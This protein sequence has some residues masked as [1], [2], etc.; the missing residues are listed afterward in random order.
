MSESGESSIE[1]Q[2]ADRRYE[3]IEQLT[4]KSVKRK[5]TSISWSD[6]LDHVFLNK[7]LGI[8]LFL[9]IMFAMFQFTFEVA[10]PLM[11]LVDW[12]FSLL[13]NWVLLVSENLYSASPPIHVA[14]WQSFLVDGLI[15]GMGSVIIFVPNI[16]LLFL[17]IAF[18]EDTGYLARA[19]FV[20]DRALYRIGLHGRSFIPMILGFGCNVPAIMACRSIEDEQDRNLTIMIN[21]LMSCGARFPVYVLFAGTFFTAIGGSVIWSM[22]IIGILLAVVMALFFRRTIFKGKPAPFI[23][24]LPMYRRPTLHGT[25]RH[26]WER[27]VHFLKKAGGIIFVIVVVVWVMANFPWGAPI[28]LTLVGILGHALSPFFAPLGFGWQAVIGIIFGFL[29]KEVVIGT[30]GV[31]FSVSEE[32]VGP[33]LMGIFT[34]ITAFA[35]LVFI[36]IYVPCIAAIGTAYQEFNSLKYTLIMVVY[37]IV[38][39]YLMA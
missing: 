32:A 4:R 9:V 22:Y 28:E 30:F 7:W 37:T 3:V 36:L 15:G 1:L 31:I 5:K 10:T 39:A 2:L 19:A 24:E 21:P 12:G 38:L 6:R 8:P 14:I 16:F 34:P 17:V 27:G 26:M 29:A 35:Y 20:M 25:F 23:L 13:G 11:D 33:A 18:L